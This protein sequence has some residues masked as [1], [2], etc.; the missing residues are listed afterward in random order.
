MIL[1][2]TE[3]GVNAG[4]SGQNDYQS[5]AVNALLGFKEQF[6]PQEAAQVVGGALGMDQA[7][8][9]AFVQEMFDKGYLGQAQGQSQSQDVG[10]VMGG[11][12]SVLPQRKTPRQPK[13]AIAEKQAMAGAQERFQD[14][15]TY[16]GP[17]A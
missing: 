2:V 9:Q 7:S 13:I 10:E 11:V 12:P 1:M 3:Q 17:K 5:G 15:T 16:R 6:S 14:L 4:Q 8:S